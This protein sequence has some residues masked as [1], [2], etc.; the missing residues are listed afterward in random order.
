ML[1]LAL[2]SS[3]TPLFDC[4]AAYA[5][6]SLFDSSA[7]SHPRHMGS[8]ILTGQRHVLGVDASPHC[9][10]LPCAD[11]DSPGSTHR[12][13]TFVTGGQHQRSVVTL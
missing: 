4:T 7:R 11:T 6:L 2:S 9:H 1:D 5:T 8:S 13:S 12:S 3:I 10:V